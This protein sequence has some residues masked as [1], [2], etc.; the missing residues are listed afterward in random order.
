MHRLGRFAEA[1]P[2]ID[3]RVS[4]SLHHVDFAREDI[5]VAVRH[6]DGSWPGLQVTRLCTEALFPACS[7]KLLRGRHCRARPPTS[8]ITCCCTSTTTATGR[9]GLKRPAWRGQT[10]ARGPVF[11][12]ASM[13]ID[14]AVDGQGV[15]LARTALAA[16]DLLAGRLVRLPF[17]PA[18][19]VP[20]A[21]DRLPARGRRSAEDHCFPRLAGRRGRRETRESCERA[22]CS[23][24]RVTRVGR[25]LCL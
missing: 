13:A 11:N 17:G 5:D 12:Q 21:L 18:L 20:Y 2:S 7:P 10:L 19:A 16:W 9:S 22:R 3:L 24:D 15:A 25:C 8:G 6:G 1:H 14:A 4:A 23:T